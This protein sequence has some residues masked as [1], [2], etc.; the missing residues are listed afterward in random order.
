MKA[1]RVN[2]EIL[3][4]LKEKAKYGLEII[5]DV[6]KAAG[7][8]IL[9]QGSAYSTLRALETEG[10]LEGYWSDEGKSLRGGRPRRYYGLTEH[11]KIVL[12]KLESERPTK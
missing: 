9:T 12:D 4:T 1:S 10:Y 6:N 7:K 5:D 8:I 3:K 11:G 2:V